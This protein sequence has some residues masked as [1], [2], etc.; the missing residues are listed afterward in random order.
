[1]ALVRTEE[2]R[3]ATLNGS[4][5]NFGRRTCA[6]SLARTVLT[7]FFCFSQ[8]MELLG[9][10]LSTSRARVERKA[11]VLKASK[12]L[13]RERQVV[14]RN[15]KTGPEFFSI[16]QTRI[17]DSA[18]VKLSI[19]RGEADPQDASSLALVE[20]GSERGRQD[21]LALRLSIELS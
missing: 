18:L 9:E 5:R 21:V 4:H 15:K 13:Q 12:G 10:A 19:E 6:P 14:L 16:L 17:V 8:N 3:E 7:F 2:T 11:K 20:T 1:M